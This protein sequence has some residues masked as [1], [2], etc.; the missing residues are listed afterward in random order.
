MYSTLHSLRCRL[1]T[2]P[3][4][5]FNN[6]EFNTNNSL[7]LGLEPEKKSMPPESSRIY[8]KD[9]R[10][11]LDL[12]VDPAASPPQTSIRCSYIPCLSRRHS[13]D[14]LI[15]MPCNGLRLRGADPR[16]GPMPG[17]RRQASVLRGAGTGITVSVILTWSLTTHFY[18]DGEVSGDWFTGW[19]PCRSRPGP[20]LPAVPDLTWRGGGTRITPDI[21]SR[22]PG[23]LSCSVML[24]AWFRSPRTRDVGWV[25]GHRPHTMA[26]NSANVSWWIFRLEFT[27]V[28]SCVW[29]RN[30]PRPGKR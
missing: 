13:R 14:E 26:R 7:C 4:F 8:S 24:L 15:H 3:L 20:V 10:C 2:S 27:R 6:L 23:P 12:Y 30:L 22:G 5:I 9:R 11:L 25:A 1:K 18:R 28:V 16:A 29:T 19:P 21:I 17:H